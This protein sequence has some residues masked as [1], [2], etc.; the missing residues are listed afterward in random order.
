MSAAERCV[1]AARRCLRVGR[2]SLS[3]SQSLDLAAQVTAVDLGLKPALLYDGNGAGVE[4]VQRYLSDLQS[5]GL[6][7]GSLLTVELAG[8]SVVINV[9]AVSSHLE[10]ALTDCSVAG[11]DVGSS[12][13]RPFMADPQTQL[14]STLQHLQRLVGDLRLQQPQQPFRVGSRSAGWNL[15]TVFGLLLGYPVVY[16]FDQ[17]ESFENCLSMTPLTLTTASVRWR[18][19]GAGHTCCLY[20]FSVPAALQKETW[21][22]MENWKL[23]LQE[24]VEQQSIFNDL[25]IA[26]S[27]VTLPAVCL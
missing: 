18:A 5:V 23:Q 6:L 24:K 20:S 2:K 11:V 14:K 16:C 12:L 22:V 25:T 4:Q 10:R 17:T 1:A 19:D 13:E 8:N 15:C 26:L 3:T 27:T 21:P 9:S 7:S